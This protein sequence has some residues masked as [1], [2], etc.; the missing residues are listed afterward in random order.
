VV[1]AAGRSVRFRG[2]PKQLIDWDGEP[3][4][5]RTVKTALASRLSQVVV[6]LGHAADE[7]APRLHG[8][9]AE[10]VR[11]PAYASGLAS[12]VRTGLAAV[13][14]AAQAALFLP[15]DQPF[16]SRA[17]LDRLA[18]AYVA[19][20]RRIVLPQA[21]GR[22]GAPVLWDRSLFGELAALTGDTGG[23][24][25]LV[26]H[27]SEVLTVEAQ[28]PVELADLDSESDRRRLLAERDRRRKEGPQVA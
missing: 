11:N 10:V 4:L 1:L 24:A 21:A 8:V 23:R 19:S 20:G 12:S 3:L 13:D 26:R 16:L 9:D 28:D 15:A 6:V 25:L 17:L 5:L 7:I 22:R 14:P 18:A 27:E 2:H